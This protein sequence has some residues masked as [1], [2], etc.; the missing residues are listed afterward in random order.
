ME[1]LRTEAEVIIVAAARD[2]AD[3]LRRQ[4]EQLVKRSGKRVG[5]FSWRIGDATY[6]V[7]TGYREIR[8]GDARMR[9][10]AAD[11]ATGDGAIPTLAIVDELHRHRSMEL[12]GILADGLEAP[13]PDIPGAGGSLKDFER[14]CLQ[15]RLDNG[16]P[17]VLESHEKEIL[18]PYFRGVPESAVILSKKNGKTTLLAALALYHL[19]V[20]TR[21]RQIVVIST[22]GAKKD[23]PLGELR[24][25]AHSLPSFKRRG[26][27]NTAISPDGS[28]AWIEWCL[29]DT[30]DLTNIRLVKRA[31]PASWHTIASLRRRL[32]SPTM[33]PGRWAR[34]A[35][36]VWTEGEEPW[37]DPKV[38]DGLKVDIGT[39]NDGEPVWVAIRTGQGGGT[40]IGIAAPRDEGVAVRAEILPYDFPGLSFALR[41]LAERY[42]VQRIYVDER[43]FGMGAQVL[44]NSG[45]P[46]A[47]LP[48]SPTRL[49]E[50]TSTFLGLVSSGNLAHDGD[51]ELRNQVMSG[52]VKEGVTGA[53]LEPTS[54]TSALVAVMLAAHEASRGP[55]RKP[56]IHVLQGAG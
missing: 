14:F 44:E 48:Q 49:M 41:R 39:V 16:K 20:G 50:A 5:V 21:V 53:Y 29:N 46:L 4:A 42:E 11:A 34:F 18:R 28:F 43:Q 25:R 52:R 22:A 23:S 24:D 13:P 10:L 45:L 2:Q 30:D 40:G 26:V 1:P 9:V 51:S 55:G 33:T 32:E 38:W 6:E 12:Y 54:H 47:D 17:F 31:N 8:Y 27:K 56:K 35:C 15:L 19:K 37:V 7:K 36:G 3:V